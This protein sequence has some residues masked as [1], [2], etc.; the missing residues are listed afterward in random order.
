MRCVRSIWLQLLCQWSTFK[1][2]GVS[3][4]QIS[5]MKGLRLGLGPKKTWLWHYTCHMVNLESLGVQMVCCPEAV[6][7]FAWVVTQVWGWWRYKHCFKRMWS[8]EQSER[9]SQRGLACLISKL[10]QS[11]RHVCPKNLFS[12]CLWPSVRNNGRIVVKYTDILELALQTSKC[13]MYT[14]VIFRGWNKK[15]RNNLAPRQQSQ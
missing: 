15:Q 11:R 3:D 4:W 10:S 14:F 8:E 7:C 12:H 13:T 6:V 9:T 1:M 5:N 2:V